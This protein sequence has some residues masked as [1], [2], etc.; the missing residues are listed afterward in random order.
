MTKWSRRHARLA[1]GIAATVTL[2]F[3][4]SLIGLAAISHA[5]STA[6]QVQKQT[7]IQ[8]DQAIH[9]LYV[10]DVRLAHEEW[11]NANYGAFQTLLDAQLPQEG[12]KDLRG[13]EW[14]YLKSLGVDDAI[15]LKG[16]ERTVADNQWKPGSSII[17][18][19]GFDHTIRLWDATT[20]KE[21]RTLARH[22]DKLQAIAWSPDGRRL[23]STAWDNT[24][25]VWDADT[26]EQLV[27]VADFGFDISWSPDGERIAICSGG[28]WQLSMTPT[29]GR[30]SFAFPGAGLN[31]PSP[32]V[33]TGRGSPSAGSSPGGNK[34]RFRDEPMVRFAPSMQ[35]RAKRFST[36]KMPMS[37]RSIASPGVSTA[38][39]W[40]ALAP[41]THSKFGMQRLVKSYSPP[42][43]TMVP[44]SKSPGR[45]PQTSLPP[46]HRTARSKIWRLGR[47][48]ISNSF[49]LHE[50]PI[51]ALAW[52]PDGQF[53][54]AHRDHPMQRANSGDLSRRRAP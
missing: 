4:V 26:G 52:S 31:G 32:T 24:T 7:A 25:R 14:Y 35:Q 28:S 45:R 37:W 30:N 41:T 29:L 20:G 43:R 27:K 40:R 33:P 51:S 9:N 21:I 47:Q 34:T 3:A 22:D 36:F 6:H 54:A 5:W 19:A 53:V 46:P 38:A 18:T 39:S 42:K 11:N 44:L 2:L 50:G 15:V 23:A 49:L 8:R 13:W 48:I 16:H 17:A 10:A 1:F 12:V